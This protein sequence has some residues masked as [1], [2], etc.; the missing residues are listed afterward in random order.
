MQ[1]KPRQNDWRGFRWWAWQGL[2]LRPLR[3][4]HSAL[5]LSYTPTLEAA[6]SGAVL[7]AQAVSLDRKPI[8]CGS[9][10]FVVIVRH[11]F[12]ERWNRRALFPLHAEPGYRT[13]PVAFAERHAYPAHMR[14]GP[15]WR[16]REQRSRCRTASSALDAGRLLKCP[17]TQSRSSSG[18]ETRRLMGCPKT[19][20]LLSLLSFEPCRS[21]SGKRPHRSCT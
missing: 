12:K 7:L 20:T 18:L 5:P 9:G 16:L 15:L 8:N 2:N 1:Q 21:Q 4:Q 14:A 17:I 10:F 13:A 6:N 3:C 11:G 19:A